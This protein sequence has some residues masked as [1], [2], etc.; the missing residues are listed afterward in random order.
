MSR[1]RRRTHR[2]VVRDIIHRRRARKEQEAKVDA[3]YALT[4]AGHAPHC[5][6][7]MYATGEC[8]CEEARRWGWKGNNGGEYR[9]EEDR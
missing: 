8:R 1:W 9:R 5:A 7:I 6:G 2:E 4:L 3:M